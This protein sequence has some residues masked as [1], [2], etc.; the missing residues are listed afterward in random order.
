[1]A[2]QVGWHTIVADARGKFAT[3]ERLPSAGEIVVGWPE[4]ALARVGP[5]YQTAVVVLTHDD[6]FDVPA[7]Q[8]AL[9]TEAFY[10]AAIGSRRTQAQRREQLVEAGLTDDELGRI[11]GPAGLDLGAD[12]PAETAFSILAEALA[13]RAARSG[14]P[15]KT[16]AGRIHVEA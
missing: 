7:L 5:D 8:A 16:A 11:H 14:T 12:S 1:M 10:V 4:E 3:K 6:K 9:R 2:K 15:L 13:V